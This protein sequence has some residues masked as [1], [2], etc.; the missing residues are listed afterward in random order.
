MT[1]SQPS[2]SSACLRRP[3][4]FSSPLPSQRRQRR[5]RDQRRLG[6][7][8]LSLLELRELPIQQVRH[9]EAEDRVA[10]ELQRLVVHHAAG[11]VL[12][13]LGLVRQRVLEQTRVPEPVADPA[14]EGR[15]RLAERHHRAR[16]PLLPVLRDDPGGLLGQLRRHGHA[17]LPQP[18]HVEGEHRRRRA[19]RLDRLD[20]VRLEQAPD[21][22]G[23]DVGGRAE[24]GGPV[25]Q[26]WRAQMVD[27]R[28][29][30]TER[31]GNAGSTE[32]I[33]IT[34]LP[35]GRCGRRRRSGRAGS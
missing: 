29:R 11:R 7:G 27:C 3:P 21:D 9:D 22:P 1:A 18:L 33:A 20:A 8:L 35:R 34:G 10:E 17:H 31:T 19:G 25:H 28:L 14:L 23:L 26:N 2:A 16:G 12:V 30:A 4:V 13:R 24:D 6:L 5:G 15:Q 32:R